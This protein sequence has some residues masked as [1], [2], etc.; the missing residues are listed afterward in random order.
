MTRGAQDLT[1]VVMA[2][3]LG[4]RY[5]GLKQIEPVGPHGEWIVDYSVFDALRAG[6]G[7]ILF[8]VREEVEATLR[9]RFDGMLRDRCETGYVRQRLDDLPAGFAAPPGR[10]KPWGTGHAVLVCRD[11][12]FGPFA[13]I[14]ADDFYGRSAYLVMATHLRSAKGHAVIGYPLASTVTGHGTVS[15]GICRV[16]GDGRLESI[17]ERK[18]VARR[19]E[20]VAYTEDGETWHSIPAGSIASMNFW[21]F[22][23]SIL[24]EFLRRFQRFLAQGPGP[25]DEFFIPGIVGELVREGVAD[26][27]VLPSDGDWF[28]VTYREDLPR[29]RRGIERLVEAGVYPSPLW[30]DT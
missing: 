15:R 13:V 24:P 27:D 20:A 26:V 8:V 5:G 3:G 6:F 12:L 30:R 4:S 29:T 23:P 9:A 21:G 18:R 25:S 11:L 10:A 2:A 22:V 19:G 1:M 28:G 17:V 14:N 7:R 16:R